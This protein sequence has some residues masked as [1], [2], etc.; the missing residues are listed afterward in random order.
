VLGQRRVPG[1]FQFSTL[2]ADVATGSGARAMNFLPARGHRD[3]ML[4]GKSRQS[5]RDFK[6]HSRHGAITFRFRRQRLTTRA[7]N[8]TWSLPFPVHH[9]ETAVAPSRRRQLLP[10]AWQSPDEPSKSPANIYA[11]Y[12]APACNVGNTLSRQKFFAE[13]LPPQ[14]CWPRS[15]K[16]F[17]RQ[18]RCRAPGPTSPTMAMNTCRNNSPAA[19]E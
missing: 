19:M 2:V 15:Y 13:D 14:P 1:V 12:T 8:A 3:A 4:F 7:Q 16:L 11:S 5:S 9:G 10:G 6:S 17:P 18:L